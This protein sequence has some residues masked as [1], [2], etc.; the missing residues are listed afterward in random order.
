MNRSYQTWWRESQ[1]TRWPVG[2]PDAGGYRVS[3]SFHE[4]A[5][6]LLSRLPSWR[7]SGVC[8][9]GIALGLGQH[10]F[11]LVDVYG[12]GFDEDDRLGNVPE[13]YR[14]RVEADREIVLHH[15][16]PAKEAA[17]ALNLPI[18]YLT[19]YLAPSTTERNEWRNMSIRTCGIDVLQAW[20]EPNDI[21]AFS[22]VIAPEEGD[23]LIK[24]QHYS[25]FFETHLESLLKELGRA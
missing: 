19:N 9:G 10:R 14:V 11:H 22:K 7:A 25:G 5:R 1:N 12:L 3:T 20:R 16:K 4:I 18:I 17:K 8:R 24:K 21:L 6:S 13:F 23:Y 2:A 15:I